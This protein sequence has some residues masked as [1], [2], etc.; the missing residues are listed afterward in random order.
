M[1]RS[2]IPRWITDPFLALIGA[3]LAAGAFGFGCRAPLDGPGEAA[4]SL[5]EAI[6][7]DDVVAVRAG[8]KAGGVPSC[9]DERGQSALHVASRAG[10]QEIV[11]ALLDAGAL[12]D[13]TDLMGRTP[14]MLA[15]LGGH[16]AAVDAL[17]RLGAQPE[18]VDAYGWTPLHLAVR[19]GK[20]EVAERF[21]ALGVDVNRPTREGTT[22]LMCAAQRAP[23]AQLLIDAGAHLDAQTS[24]GRTALMLAAASRSGSEVVELLLEFGAKVERLDND[25]CAA[26]SYA[27]RAGRTASAQALLTAGADVNRMNRHGWTPLQ[28]AI[29]TGERDGLR[30][31]HVLLGAGAEVDRKSLSGQTALVLACRPGRPRL[32][33][34][35]LRAGA[36]VHAPVWGL[37][38]VCWAE[39]AGNPEVLGVLLE[40]GADPGDP[41]GRSGVGQGD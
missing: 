29:L 30:M 36:D 26:L 18:V 37:S 9:R 27:A 24:M 12:A 1:S 13:V 3:L 31:A 20:G 25:G 22:P 17:L 38:P 19:S 11:E 32:V 33:R 7:E 41:C 28:E 14:L 34:K 8:L 40:H 2:F 35:L 23:M 10:G 39:A 6:E 21:L 15:A 5:F 4:C 16:D